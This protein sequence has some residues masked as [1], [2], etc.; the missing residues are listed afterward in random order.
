MK[1]PKSLLLPLSLLSYSLQV[2]WCLLLWRK[3]SFLLPLFFFKDLAIYF[4]EKGKEC[5]GRGGA[6]REKKRRE[7][8]SLL[9]ES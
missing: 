9:S 5:M 2:Y 3:T 8:D 6:E 1:V 7:A 4:G